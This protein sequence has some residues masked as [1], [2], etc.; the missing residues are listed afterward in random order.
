MPID[1]AIFVRARKFDRAA[2]ESFFASNYGLVHRIA[3]ALSGR[4]NVGRGIVRFVL[5]RAVRQLPQWRDADSAE[6]WFYHFTVLIARRAAVQRTEIGEDCL[7]RPGP[8]DPAY[9]AFIRCLRELPFQ[10]SEAFILHHGEKLK[11]RDLAIAMDC[12]THAAEQHLMAGTESLQKLSGGDFENL[13]N[14][15]ILAYSQ[16]MPGEDLARPALQRVIARSIWA[17]R[18]KRLLKVVI[19]LVVL[20]AVAYGA[21]KWRE[22]LPW[23]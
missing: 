9:V 11:L 17:R 22:F 4:E 12:S 16:L 13:T 15:L 3:Y 20:G 14:K 6:R 1:P 19:V 8:V 2:L 5:G 21:W 23:L 7:I 10:Q 18:V